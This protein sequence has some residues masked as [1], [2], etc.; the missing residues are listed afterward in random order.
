MALPIRSV[1][2]PGVRLGYRDAGDPAAPPVVLLHGGRATGER[3]EPVLAELAGRYRVLAPDQRGHGASRPADGHGFGR[4]RDDLPA[5]AA[6][7]GLRRFCL[8]GHSMGGTVAILA[9]E[10]YPELLSGLVLVDTPPPRGTGDWPDPERPAGDLPY[11]W[12]AVLAVFAGLRAPD[13]AWWDDLPT[14]TAPTLVIGGGPTSHVPQDLLAEAAGRIPG[15]AFTTVDGAG[16]NVYRTRQAEFLD[17]LRP[18]LDR[19]S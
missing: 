12:E 3:W 10:R 4:M 8:V 5:F 7:L 1:D 11:D 18:F 2:L 6:A 15:A 17:L 14:I 9:A 16:H 13:P 19:V